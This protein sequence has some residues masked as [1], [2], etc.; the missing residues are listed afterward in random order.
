[1]LY[2]LMNSQ[3]LIFFLNHVSTPEFLK[4]L[5]FGPYSFGVYTLVQNLIF[6]TLKSL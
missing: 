5:I 6:L 2:C 4:I 3:I 1:M